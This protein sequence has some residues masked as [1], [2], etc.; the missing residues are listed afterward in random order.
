MIFWLRDGLYL[1]ILLENFELISSFLFFVISISTPLVR[2]LAL[3]YLD[4]SCL[5][6]GSTTLPDTIQCAPEMYETSGPVTWPIR[7]DD[8]KHAAHKRNSINKPNITLIIWMEPATP[9]GPEGGHTV[10]TTKS[11]SMH[12]QQRPVCP[13]THSTEATT[14]GRQASAC[15]PLLP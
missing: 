7:W 2:V 3:Y 15:V 10:H 6:S 5:V 13:H 14:R 9:H 11:M 1:Y 8:D 4:P 12:G